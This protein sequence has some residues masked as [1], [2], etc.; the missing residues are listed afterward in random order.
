MADEL[1]ATEANVPQVSVVGEDDTTTPAPRTV[2]T[3]QKD[4]VMSEAPVDQ[5]AVRRNPYVNGAM[6]T[7]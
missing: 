1:P 6:V 5:P 4:V 7:F 2:D 3:P